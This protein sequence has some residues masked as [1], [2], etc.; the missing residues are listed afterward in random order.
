MFFNLFEKIPI[1]II[2]CLFI[3]YP[4]YMLIKFF[5]AMRKLF[6]NLQKEYVDNKEKYKYSYV[7]QNY[8]NNTKVPKYDIKKPLDF[9]ILLQNTLTSINDLKLNL[10]VKFTLVLPYE[11]SAIRNFEDE[12]SGFSEDGIKN[13]LEKRIKNTMCLV[14]YSTDL[15]R[16]K[17]FEEIKNAIATEIKVNPTIWSSVELKGFRPEGI[18]VEVTEASKDTE[19]VI[20]K[21]YY[22][23]EAFNIANKYNGNLTENSVEEI[24]NTEDRTQIENIQPENDNENLNE[25]DLKP[26]ENKPKKKSFDSHYDKD[27]TGNYNKEL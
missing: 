5:S 7:N 24:E 27:L 18:E 26:E 12:F 21:E 15:S 13:F 6:N 11:K 14:I 1:I 16:M 19:I 17:N 2:V 9:D 20:K 4:I 22:A 10:S 25:I 3:F 23:K 8:H